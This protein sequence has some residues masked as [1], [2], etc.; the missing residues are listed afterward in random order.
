M[1][2]GLGCVKGVGK[3]PEKSGTAFAG[4]ND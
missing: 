3:A 2:C 4:E 1:F